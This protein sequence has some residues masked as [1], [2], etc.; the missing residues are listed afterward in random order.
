MLSKIIK[1][2]HLNNTKLEIQTRSDLR[3]R[4]V[5]ASRD[6]GHAADK[7]RSEL[8]ENTGAIGA[9]TL[10]LAFLSSRRDVLALTALW[11]RVGDVPMMSD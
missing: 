2:D 1:I 5:L 7:T 9:K 11:S 6:L 4:L 8:N 3:N 10:G